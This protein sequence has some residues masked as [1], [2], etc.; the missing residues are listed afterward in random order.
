[1]QSRQVARQRRQQRPRRRPGQDQAR[2]GPHP[3]PATL[4]RPRTARAQ[5]ASRLS[6]PRAWRAR[7]PTTSTALG[8][9][10]AR[11][12][13][14]VGFRKGRTKSNTSAVTASVRSARRIQVRS[15]CT[16][17]APRRLRPE[18]GTG[19]DHLARPGPGQKMDQHRQPTATR[20]ASIHG[21]ARDRP[22]M[23]RSS[24]PATENSAATARTDRRRSAPG[25][26]RTRAPAPGFELRQERAIPLAV[27]RPISSGSALNGRGRLRPRGTRG[28]Q[29]AAPAPPVFCTTWNSSTSKRERRNR[30]SRFQNPAELRKSLK[31]ASTPRR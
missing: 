20:P 22:L 4:R 7:R 27:E 26:N 12:G 15:R 8:L 13:A 9:G 28:G 5:T 17:G 30:S 29:S 19:K 6:A 25:N 2:L 14:A 23:V 11:P 1:V 21:L 3:S 18:S 10:L 31:M 16:P 24:L